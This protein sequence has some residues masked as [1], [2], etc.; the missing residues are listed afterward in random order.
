MIAVSALTIRRRLVRLRGSLAAFACVAALTGAVV[1]HHTEMP[2]SHMGTDMHGMVTVVMCLG[3]LGLAAV[4]VAALPKL[5][6]LL[7]GMPRPRAGRPPELVLASTGAHPTRAGP[8]RFLV[9][10]VVRR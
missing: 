5:G 9:L 3:V 1:A 4:A 10:A 6:R 2:G 8:A 7:P